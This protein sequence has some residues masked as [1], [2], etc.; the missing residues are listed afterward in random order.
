MS[1][2]VQDKGSVHKFV[3]YLHAG[4]QH[5]CQ[6]IGAKSL[7]QLRYTQPPTQ[8]IN[9]KQSCTQVETHRKCVHADLQVWAF[10]VY[11]LPS[12]VLFTGRWCILVIWNLRGELCLLRW[13]EESIVYTGIHTAL[14]LKVHRPQHVLWKYNKSCVMHC[15]VKLNEVCVRDFYSPPA[16]LM[17][18]LLKKIVLINLII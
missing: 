7:T 4:I 3:P 16:P 5:S 9:I 8:R 17:I 18:L 12:P 11:C 10:S 13:R 1:G 14:D 6:D 2:A 15:N